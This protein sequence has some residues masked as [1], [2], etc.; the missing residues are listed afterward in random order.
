M[1]GR[2]GRDQGLGAVAPGDAQ[3]V[4]TTRHGF[5][6]QC[7]DVDLTGTLEQAHLRPER[8]GA[9]PELEPLDLAVAGA[10]VHQEERPLG[11]SDVVL[12][13]PAGSRR[14]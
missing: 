6:G 12:P 1:L 11:G 8:L 13:Q 9:L 5:P 7:G 2:D 14:P 4:R 3:E 10:R